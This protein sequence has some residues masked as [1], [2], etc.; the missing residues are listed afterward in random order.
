MVE[1]DS[2]VFDVP[3]VEEP[4]HELVEVKKKGRKPMSAERK[5]E[6][7]ERLR[8]GKEKKKALKE[9]ALKGTT[10]PPKKAKKEKIVE[11]LPATT[12]EPA[13]LVKNVRKTKDHTDDINSL[14]AE[15]AE[16]KLHQNSKQDLAEIKQLKSELKAMRDQKRKEKLVADKNVKVKQTPKLEMKVEPVKE[17]ATLPTATLPTATLPVAKPAPRYTTYKKSIWS[18]LL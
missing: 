1:V 13:V 18:Q 6:L 3:K 5:A 9:A 17:A 16:M 7:V 8:L 15:I 4:T 2:E 11:V 14:K 12:T 10:P